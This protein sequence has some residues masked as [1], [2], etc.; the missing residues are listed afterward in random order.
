MLNGLNLET[1]LAIVNGDR[2]PLREAATFLAEHNAELTTRAI[3]SISPKEL[4]SPEWAAV[5]AAT[6]SPCELGVDDPR[7]EGIRVFG[8]ALKKELQPGA[9][10]Q[11]TPGTKVYLRLK[12]TEDAKAVRSYEVDVE[13]G[14]LIGNDLPLNWG[15][16]MSRRPEPTGFMLEQLG[17]VI[18]QNYLVRAAEPELGLPI[19]LL[20]ITAF[21]PTTNTVTATLDSDI[22]AFTPTEESLQPPFRVLG[23]LGDL[24]ALLAQLGA[25]PGEAQTPE[26]GETAGGEGEKDII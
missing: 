13:Q 6:Y 3:V 1:A 10:V 8:P 7:A 5:V 12:G 2:T 11:F 19:P 17:E 21:D 25:V 24:E 4:H 22:E 15:F 9:T 23:G 18:A 16:Q 14:A 26:G 20:Q